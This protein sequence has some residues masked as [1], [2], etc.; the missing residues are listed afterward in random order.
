LGDIVPRQFDAVTLL[1]LI[2]VAG[3]TIPVHGTSPSAQNTEAHEVLEN[4]VIAAAGDIACDPADPS[5]NGGLGTATAC[6]MK[7]TSDL[8]VN[9]NPAAVFTLGDNEQSDGALWK[10][11]QSF[12]P[13]WGRVKSI[14]HPAVGNHEYGTP[15]ASGYFSYFGTAAG[16]PSKGYYS[17]DIGAWHIIVLNGNCNR[18]GG[19]GAGSPQEQW[20]KEDL[21][22]SPAACTLAYWH[23]PRFSSGGHG[24]NLAYDAWWQDLYNAG[25]DVVLNGHDHYYERF[26]PQTPA[27]IADQV[28]GIREFVVGTGGHSHSLFGSIHSTSEVRNSDTFGILKLTLR[29]DSY[30][31]QFVPESGRQFTDSG[32]GRCHSTLRALHVEGNRIVDDKGPAVILRGVSIEDPY[33]LKYV[34]NRLVEEDFAVLSADWH[35][36]VVR[37]PIHPELWQYYPDQVQEVLDTT[38]AWGGKYGIYILLGW[39]AHGNPITGQTDSS[40]WAN[41]LPWHGNPYNPDMNLARQFWA[42][43]SERYKTNSWVIY[44]V[45]DEPAYISWPEWRPLAEELVDAIRQHNPEA[46]TLVPGTDWSYDLSG[47]ASDPVRRTNLV[48]EVHPF[49]GKPAASACGDWDGCFGFLSRDYPVF[50]GGWGFEPESE[51]LNL[52]ATRYSYGM[53]LLNYMTR[54]GMSWTAWCWSPSWTPRMLQSWTCEPTDFGQLVKEALAG[55]PRKLAFVASF[56]DSITHG[57]PYGAGDPMQAVENTYPSILQSRLDNQIGTVRYVVVN[58]GINGLK[59]EELRANLQTQGWLDE[60]PVAVLIMIGGNDLSAATSMGEFM[61]LAQETVQEVQDIVDI[62]KAHVNPDGGRPAV[63]V[64]AFPPNLLGVLANQGIMYY[65]GLLKSQLTGLDLFFSD[66]F[67]DLYDSTSGDANVGLMYDTVHPNAAGYAL[68]AENYQTAL[69]QVMGDIAYSRVSGTVAADTAGRLAMNAYSGGAGTVYLAHLGG[70]SYDEEFHVVD[71]LTAGSTVGNSGPVLLVPG[72]LDVPW[73]QTELDTTISYL[74]QL[75][76]SQVVFLGSTGSISQ[77]VEDYVRSHYPSATY[78]RIAGTVAADTAGLLAVRAFPNGASTVYIGHLGGFTATDEFHIV[79]ALTAG[80]SVGNSAPVLLVP[81]SMGPE[82]WKKVEVDTTI[83]Y[84]GVLGAWN[85]VILGSIGSITQEV[86]DYLKANYPSATYSRVSGTI[87]ADTAGMLALMAYPGGAPT[88]YLSH[89]GGFTSAEEFHVVDALTAGS[90]VGNSGPVLLVPGNLDAPWKQT[91]L[92]RT[93]YYLNQLHP[94]QV[95][96]LGGTGSISREVEDYVRSHCG[97][98]IPPSIPASTLPPP[99]SKSPIFQTVLVLAVEP[100]SPSDT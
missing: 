8:L 63:I 66:N 73:K 37:V 78:D 76:P 35:V 39:H 94:S 52:R 80:A 90:T 1:L 58:H 36:N 70:F 71:A 54:K 17:F 21:A 46:L 91:E 79:D 56:G 3:L 81:G 12:D 77:Q 85:V 32:T 34:E 6:R 67:D 29:S 45:F 38:V 55:P 84:L 23:Q 16:D 44:S 30:D 61:R 11:Q 27:G 40:Q 92:D 31:W 97:S 88:V 2:S 69:V 41:D 95:V 19:C 93:I 33:F 14:I 62:V 24:D 22:A 43:A 4:P 42:F 87:A 48:Y 26:A 83:H 75:R 72:N 9:L 68:I 10:F 98:S 5:Y 89:L 51:D 28:Y 20:L 18:V 96:F 99:P 60:N 65:N 25:A 59:A 100:R 64:S 49:P 57:Y 47:A 13:T 7:Y 74:N 50:V 15:G 86:Q 53:P 82:A